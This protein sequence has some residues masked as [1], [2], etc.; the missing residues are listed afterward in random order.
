MTELEEILQHINTGNNF[1][2]SGGA[3]SGKTYSLVEVITEVI[4]LNPAEKIFCMTYTNIAVKEIAE[5]VNHKNLKVSTIHDFLWDNIKHFQKEIKDSLVVL[6]NDDYSKIK[7]DNNGEIIPDDY[8]DEIEKIEYKEFLKIKEG[9]VSHDEIILLSEYMFRTYIKLCDILKDKY[10]FIF[11]DEYQDTHKEVVDILLRHLKRSSRKNIIGFFGDAMQSIYESGVDDINIYINDNLLKEVQKKQNRRSP[12]LVI[13]LANKLRTDGIEQEPSTDNSAPNMLNGVIKEGTIKFIHSDNPDLEIVREYLKEH[14]GW[15]FNDNKN[16]KEL[17][18]THNLIA[19]KAGFENL[20]AIYDKDHILSFRNRIKKYIK[21]NNIQED[22]S[23]KSFGEVIEFLQNGKTGRALNQVSPTRG[24]QTFIDDNLELYEYAKQYNYFKLLKIYLDKEQFLDDKKQT[25]NEEKKKGSKRDSLI[26]HLFKIQKAISLYQSKKYNEFMKVTD[27]TINSI[28]NKKDLKQNIEALVSLEDKTIE[29]IINEADSYG[30][31]V[32][33]DKLNQF[34]TDKEY[35]YNRVKKV[36]FSEFKNLFEY[37]EGKT[38]FTTQHKTKGD[39]FD[40]V[41]VILD[42]GK[43]TQYNFENLFLEN[44]NSES[45]LNRTKKL[46][47]VCC[48]R[49]KDSL[50]VFYH[51]PSD[52]VIEKA[53]EWFEERN[54]IGI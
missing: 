30:I 47:Y 18:L 52:E 51:N 15:D 37:L 41:L 35:V 12:N 53:K 13:E 21:E 25:E 4:R 31:C 48:T 11:V 44:G 33:D 8:F 32:K 22:F 14:Y 38:P 40:N 16:L 24:M 17:N 46:F 42:N 28:Q 26:K 39:E 23:D 2:L 6:A 27:Y 3:G 36:E 54:I 34:I 45:V 43:W 19:N 9:I 1:L 49:A 20:M 10:K 29:E 50:V 7:I 5:R